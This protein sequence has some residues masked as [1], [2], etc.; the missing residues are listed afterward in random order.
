M[1]DELKAERGRAVEVEGVE[2]KKFNFKDLE[3]EHF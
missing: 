3:E 2:K 1:N